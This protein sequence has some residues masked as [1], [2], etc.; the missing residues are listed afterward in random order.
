MKAIILGAG[1]SKS[2]NDS[3]SKQRM[4]IAKDFFETYRN[5]DI[6]E[7]PWVLVGHFINYLRDY[8]NISPLEFGKYNIDI[9]I[10]HSEIEENLRE[11]L[12]NY[13]DDD[14]HNFITLF[15]TFKAYIEL[16]FLFTNV[17]NEVQ[18][19]P[20]SI[21]HVNLIS[22]L[23]SEDVII[24]FNWD[25]LVDRALASMNQWNCFDGY[26]VRPVA[27]YKNEWLE[28]NPEK[29]NLSCP[30]ILKLHGSTNWLTSAPVIERG[31]M[32]NIQEIPSDKFFVYESTKQP[33]S[34]Y[35]GRYMEGYEDF[36]YGY[37]PPNLP[38]EGKPLPNGFVLTRTI[39]RNEFTPKGKSIDKGL[40]SIPL[41][42][43]PVKNKSYDSFGELFKSLWSKAEETLT[44]A[45]E[46]I[47][48]GYSFPITDHQ[49]DILFRKAFSKRKTIPKIII[50][51]PFPELISERF[52]ISLG[53]P[54]ENI[55]VLKDYFSE[56]F[57][58]SK[59]FN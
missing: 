20:V 31:K 49:S 47:I 15:Q 25:T 18:N 52:H 3:I 56:T 4:P 26:Y 7:N 58:L 1:A 30:L 9:E 8:H 37:Y 43:P 27:V 36:S 50:V 23:N 38:L 55:T 16:I 19:G 39:L 46:I 53:I 42:I 44:N 13:N 28:T 12:L 45:D 11:A 35:D 54:L 32:Q 33:F 2:Y 41:I 29:E 21:P 48:I 14:E 57:N 10:I 59:I 24:T 5:L 17:I 51:N 34:T 22:Q 40:N 6:A